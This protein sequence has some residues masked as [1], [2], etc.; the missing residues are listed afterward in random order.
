MQLV[1]DICTTIEKLEN[2]PILVLAGYPKEDIETYKDAGV[3]EF[4]YVKCNVLET[5]GRFQK[6][7]GIIE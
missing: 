3:E 1:P 6:K 4:I 2:P 7:L 5:L